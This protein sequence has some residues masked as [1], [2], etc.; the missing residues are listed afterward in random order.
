M[1]SEGSTNNLDLD[2]A[3]KVVKNPKELFR[4]ILEI[5]IENRYSIA[6]WRLPDQQAIHF[7]LDSDGYDIPEEIDLKS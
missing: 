7:I 6:V 5:A 4:D 3:I 2:E 1:R